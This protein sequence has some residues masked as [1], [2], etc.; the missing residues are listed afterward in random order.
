MSAL[1]RAAV[2]SAVVRAAAML[3]VVR[4]RTTSAA[5]VAAVVRTTRRLPAGRARRHATTAAG[6][7]SSMNSSRSH[8]AGGG[9]RRTRRWWRRW[10]R[11]RRWRTRRRR[12]AMMATQSTT[13]PA[14]NRAESNDLRRQHSTATAPRQL[15]RAALALCIL[16]LSA[17]TAAQ[18]TTSQRTFAGPD[19][20]VNALV[21]AAKKEIAQ[22]CWRSSARERKA[23]FIGRRGRRSRGNRAIRHALRKEARSC[24][25]SD[26]RAKLTVDTDNW[27]FAF[28][29]VKTEKGWRFD[30]VAA[31]DNCSRAG[32]GDNGLSVMNVLF[33]IVHAQRRYATRG[34]RRRRCAGVPT[35]ICRAPPARKTVCI[36][37]PR[38][39][40]RRVRWATSWPT[41]PAKATR[42]RRDRSRITATTSGC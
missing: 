4:A 11:A 21:E 35:K 34:S 25:D 24:S 3:V 6:A 9:C 13:R 12:P 27:P 22:A 20:A 28:P 7:S 8:R 33:A 19:E 41:L 30:T 18:T 39:A 17:G 31:N 32:S 26:T 1:V 15:R 2:M 16:G 42:K 14:T 40:K 29:L 37:A 23:H 10:R 5:E 36:G 38:L